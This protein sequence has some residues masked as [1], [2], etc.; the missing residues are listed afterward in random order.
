MKRSARRISI[1]IT[2]AV[3][4]VLLIGNGFTSAFAQ[5]V[6]EVVNYYEP[7]LPAGAQVY[8]PE[9]PEILLAEQ[10]YAKSAILIEAT[11]GKIIFEKNADQMMYPA[12]TTKILTVFLGIIKGDLESEVTATAESVNLPYGSSSIPLELGETINFKDLLYATMIRSGNDGANLIAETVAGSVPAFVDAMNQAAAMIGCT[13]THFTNPSGLDDINH[14]TTAHDMALIAKEAMKNDLFR[15][16]VST[17]TYSLPRSNIR[18]SR[19]MVGTDTNWLNAA[20]DNEFYY[21]Y[22]I[23]I[24]TGFLNRSGYCYVGAAQKDGVELISVVFYSSK[25]GRWTDSIKL[26]N[27][28]FTQFVSVTPMELYAMNPTVIATSSYSLDDPD[29]GRL[30]LGIRASMNTRPVE[31]V[32]TIAEVEQMARNLRENVLIE[33][34]RDTFAAPITMGETFG[35]LTYYP[36]DG[37]DPAVYELYATRSI[38]RRE[39]AFKT[40]AEIKE[41]VYADPNPF[42]PFSLEVLFLLGWP[43]L[44]LIAVI[45]ILR[46]VFRKKNKRGRQQKVPKPK[47]R[48]FR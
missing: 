10:L 40:I 2:A 35:T 48:Y 17:F 29:I 38:T 14:Y 8:D 26:M 31:I 12:S 33:Y 32:S 25:P 13:G 30:Q 20:D 27:Y 23:G 34:T 46:R 9:H 28:G 45:L 3:F 6:A 15:D 47:N 37:G 18:G 39:N 16:I 44:I 4:A 21:P 7:Q 19:V 1:V 24:K 42:P 11:S 36:E 43:F 41:E 22:A 5:D